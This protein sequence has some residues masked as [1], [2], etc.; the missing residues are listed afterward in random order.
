MFK[1]PDVG[2]FRF[3]DSLLQNT[4]PLC[5]KTPQNRAWLEAGDDAAIFDGWVVTKDLSVENTHFRLDW[6]T[7][8]Q[9]VE[10]HIV[11]NVSDLSAMGALPRFAFLGLCLNKSWS[12]DVKQRV[13]E[14]LSEG[15]AKRGITLLG[16]DTVSAGEGFFS[17]TLVGTL[18]GK[19]PLL[20]SSVRPGDNLYVDGT[21]G[22]SG[23]GLWLLMNHPEDATRFPSL[24]EYHL[25]P[26][27]CESSGAELVGIYEKHLDVLSKSRDVYPACM[28]ISDGLS[29]ELNHLASASDVSI[30]IDERL[31]PI[32]PDVLKMCN[33][34]G[35]NPLDFALNGG[36]E[37]HL[38]FAFPSTNYIFNDEKRCFDRARRIGVAKGCSSKEKVY[39]RCRNG[40]T[41]PLEPRAW[42]HI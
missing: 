17:T 15:F 11:S 34:Y 4:A 40:E 8:E 25:C 19:S 18:V 7:P 32:D 13:K 20:R 21:L 36:E 9:A 2:E 23:A 26:K 39:M 37:Y 29:S 1:F 16:G 22:K 38:L 5:K 12:N 24:V 10:K 41:K 27:I 35:L 42:S 3:V 30:E 6:G 33:H 28:D 31:L 14:A